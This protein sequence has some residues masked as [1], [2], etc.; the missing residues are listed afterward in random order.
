MAFKV[1]IWELLFVVTDRA[2]THI[3]SEHVD[4]V[5]FDFGQ[6]EAKLPYGA[7]NTSKV[8]MS[9]RLVPIGLTEL[10]TTWKPTPESTSPE[11]QF[12]MFMAVPVDKVYWQFVELQEL[13]YGTSLH[14]PHT[15]IVGV[16]GNVQLPVGQETCKGAIPPSSMPL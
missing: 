1:S 2:F 6:G 5:V 13:V 10:D 11:N 4:D 14:S 3:Q 16:T 15:A 8:A 12:E 7:P 9:S